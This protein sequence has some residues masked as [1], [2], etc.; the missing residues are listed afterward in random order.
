[1]WSAGWVGVGGR[2]GKGG[3]LKVR[4]E[5][6]KVLV[7]IGGPKTVDPLVGGLS[8]N[9]PEMQIRAT[10]GLVNAY[11]PG[12]SKAGVAGTLQRA[13]NAIRARFGDTNEQ[14]IDEFVQVKPEVIQSLGRLAAGGSSLDSPGHPAPALGN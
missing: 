5:A 4:N 10:D 14:V 9:D 7:E 13:G 12:Y 1:M 6:V 11:L 3:G 8:E 2:E